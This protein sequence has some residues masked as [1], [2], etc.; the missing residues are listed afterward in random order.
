MADFNDNV[1][2]VVLAGGHLHYRDQELT[3]H[4][5]GAPE[6]VFMDLDYSPVTD[7]EGRPIAVLGVVIDT[8]QRV[9]AERATA[10]SAAQLRAYITASS[11]VLYRMSPDW[12]RLYE[13]EGRGFLVDAKASSADWLA[14][15]IDPED[16][17][18]LQERIAEAVQTRGAFELEHRVRRLD[19][20]LGWAQS[21]AL[22]NAAGEIT[23]W[24]GT[25][26]DITE[27][28]RQEALA[29]AQNRVLQLAIQDRPLEETLGALIE[30]V[31]AYSDAGTLA[32]ILILDRETNRLVHGAAPSALNPES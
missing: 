7:D 19:G 25:A 5:H 10:A 16:Q 29:L 13:L 1:L 28:K 15:Y 24:L 30:A 9:T 23:E 4:R 18:R 2:R 6:Q 20:S 22:F 31:E 21:R 14:T 27:R 32:S 17:A 8:S 12:S 11:H 26:S 3:L